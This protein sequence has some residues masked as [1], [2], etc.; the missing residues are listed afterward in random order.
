[1][2]TEFQFYKI[3]RVLEMNGSDSGMTMWMYLTLLSHTLKN[4]QDGQFYVTCILSQLK[5]IKNVIV[6]QN[7]ILHRNENKWSIRIATN[8]DVVTYNVD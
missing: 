1:M 3:R 4:G 8:T 7:G 5:I 6:W 2:V